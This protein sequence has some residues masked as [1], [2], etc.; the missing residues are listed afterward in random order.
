MSLRL[1]IGGMRGSRPALGGSFD[2]FGGDTT[3]LLLIG[4]RG[5]RLILDAGT[6]M[7]AVAE[8]CSVPVRAYLHPQERITPD[9]VTTNEKLTPDGVTP[10][11]VTV[12]FSHYHL[13]H[14]AGL[15]M[16]PLFYRRDWSL[17]FLGPTFADGGVRD[18]VT[19]LLA[20][21][22]WPVSWKQMQARME[23]AEFPGDGLE[24]GCLQMR[25]CPV[26]H[27]GG[28]LAYRIDDS[29]AGTSVVFAT[30]IE[31]R[32]RTPSQEA[33]FMALCRQPKP[34][35]LLIIDAHFAEKDQEAFAG[36]GHSSREDGL[37]V[38]QAAGIERVLLGHHAPE[39][40]DTTLRAVEQRVKDLSPGGALA[41]AGQWLT[42]GD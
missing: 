3:S 16:N 2:E 20:Q 28:C 26:P 22:Y 27:P 34:A 8:V 9:G 19:R 10:N 23:F 31:W 17:R 7:R 6:G 13:D 33:A 35:N 37:A 25:A 5:E 12:L 18:A 24:V 4:S 15:T 38:A 41:R 32:Q 1:F 30:D 29:D 21:P 39:A 42:V 40:D 36:W 11:A 14:M